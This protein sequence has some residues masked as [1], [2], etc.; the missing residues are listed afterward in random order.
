[1]PV[2]LTPEI[3][4]TFLKQSSISRRSKPGFIVADIIGDRMN[5]ASG[6]NAG[7]S[8]EGQTNPTITDDWRFRG[9]QYDGFFAVL[10]I[11]FVRFLEDGRVREGSSE[12]NRSERGDDL[13]GWILDGREALLDS[14][15]A[16]T[17]EDIVMNLFLETA[18]TDILWQSLQGTHKTVRPPEAPH[19]CCILNTG[20]DVTTKA[21][22]VGTQ[23]ANRSVRFDI[24][25]LGQ[26]PAGPQS[27]V[28]CSVGGEELSV[29]LAHKQR[30]TVERKI[31]GVW[32]VL[33]KLD[34]KQ[35]I[36]LHGG[37]YVIRF[38]RI[39]GR[40]V[41][42][43]NDEHFHF[44]KVKQ[45]QNQP[46]MAI[47]DSWS[48]GP[49]TV[50]TYNCR[51]RIGCGLIKYSTAAGVPF[52]GNFS[53][54]CPRK[55]PVP[56][57]LA[58][59]C[60][61]WLRDGATALVA[62]TVA[63]G[64]LD[65]A[66]TMTASTDGI[67]TPLVNKVMIRSE[68]EWE[69]GTP[70]ALDAATC[71]TKW[72]VSMAMPP[73]MPG[74]T[75]TF[76]IDRTLLNAVD[77]DWED[78]IDK[79]CPVE[80]QVR[81]V[82]DDGSTGAWIKLFK[83]YVY[84]ITKGTGGMNQ[85]TMTV[86]CRDSIMRLQKPAAVIDHRYPPLDILLFEA[87]AALTGQNEMPAVYGGDCVYE[88]LKIALGPDVADTIN[89]N[90]NRQRYFD[91]TTHTPLLDNETGG[92]LP[93]V[94]AASGQRRLPTQNG[95]FFPPPFG[96]DAADFINQIGK[97]DHALFMYAWPGGYANNWPAPVYGRRK[98]IID[99]ISGGVAFELPD[100][101]SVAGDIDKL[102]LSADNET[103]PWSEFNRILIWAD[104]GQGGQSA[105]TP[106]VRMAEGRLPADD[107]NSAENTWEN[108]LILRE[109]VGYAPGMAERIK[110]LI[111]ADITGVELQWPTIV[112]MGQATL[113]WGMVVMPVME[114]TGTN[115][116]YS[117]TTLGLN[118]KLFRIEKVQHEGTVGG[119][120][121]AF[122][123]TIWPR[124]LTATEAAE[125]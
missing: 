9:N 61:G 105:L 20:A 68:P 77:E 28:R 55:T 52:T 85:N 122:K 15:A 40:L 109:D 60:A 47:D 45:V 5:L 106:A 46:G 101:I 110:D 124:P 17:P 57:D 84:Q 38:R 34:T 100:V 48:A 115:G 95:F 10:G 98:N 104:G 33:R 1:M 26:D 70:A 73:I 35:P 16:N 111:L 89:G 50:S 113:Q 14:K 66:V 43:I 8:L 103:R 32:T 87:A 114:A 64:M 96:S 25:A 80:F 97:L 88:I 118:G 116:N 2:K 92:Y 59:H 83:G 94:A 74:A 51:A 65:Y 72:R 3:S 112:C 36:S 62:T 81:W 76:D 125:F 107:P 58:G 24:F 30:P 93:V 12:Q 121:D 123:T 49:L 6:D 119:G 67:D 102:I 4:L 54:H 18:N 90:G 31:N 63:P 13:A 11:D 39:G 29:R 71:V 120:D 41:V 27:A 82:Y 42:G 21:R 37:H 23:P 117:D 99:A 79:R 7:L 53:R 86:T 44:I 69:D 22:T 19:R 78:Y 91:M 108:T 56:D 75:A